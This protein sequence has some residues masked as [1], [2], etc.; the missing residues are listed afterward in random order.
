MKY[1]YTHLI[2]IESIIV[3]LDK[4]DLS[5]DQRIHLTGLIDSSLHH[6]I[7]DAVLSELKP[8]DKRI[9][10]THLQEN[11]HSKIWKF[12]N[13]KVENIEDK[14]KKTAGDLKEEL[15]KDLKEAKNK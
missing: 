3:E 5:D 13:E 8:V 15:K 11:D 2:E 12:L 10:L 14:I 7:L 4:L 1:F 9:F 6:T